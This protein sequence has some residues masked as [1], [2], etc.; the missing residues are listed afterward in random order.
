VLD[1]PTDVLESRARENLFTIIRNLKE[2]GV[3][4]VFISHRYAEVYELGDQVT[5]LRDGKNVGT[6]DIKEIS[7][8]TMIEKMIGRKMERQ[9]LQLPIPREE[10]ALKLEA[11]HKEGVLKNIHFSVKKGEIIS[12]TGLMG[13]GKTE[14]ARVIAGVDPKTRGIIYV[15]GEKKDIRSPSD[16]IRY[17]ISF[18]TENRKSEG[19]IL[20]H[21]VRNNY[22][23]TNVDRLSRLGWIH[24]RKMNS[25]TDSFIQQLNIKTPS[26]FTLAGQ[27][28]G[29]NQ[30]KLVLAKWLGT[31][32]K[33]IIFDEPTRGV[34]ILGRRDVYH[35]ILELAQKGT[36]IIVFTSDYTEALEISH[37]ILI[38]RRGEICKEFKRG[39]TTEE[40]ILKTAI[41]GNLENCLLED[42]SPS[43]SAE[44]SEK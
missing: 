4:F 19:L 15:E 24:F 23:L 1:E 17:G 29:G 14:L 7:F 26:R 44:P 11:I 38:M 27:L 9:Y 16:A 18:L 21:T 8:E 37:R 2:Q 5:I 31:N 22:G 43:Y 39:E 32:A 6:F 25:E 36:A 41:G 10:E 13:S 42:S 28:S 35:I 3:G 33:V 20:D 40:V 12:I 34:D 30:Q